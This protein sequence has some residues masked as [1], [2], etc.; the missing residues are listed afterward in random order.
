VQHT[1]HGPS[2]ERRQEAVAVCDDGIELVIVGQQRQHV[3]QVSHRH[4]PPGPG[5]D[6]RFPGQLAHAIR[7]AL[8]PWVVAEHDDIV[9]TAGQAVGERVRGALDAATLLPADRQPVTHHRDSETRE[10]RHQAAWTDD[11]S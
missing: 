4:P 3:A 8:R 10:S 7:G 2:D 9:I 5:V 6:E 1:Q 11:S